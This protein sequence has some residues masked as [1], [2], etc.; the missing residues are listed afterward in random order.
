MLSVQKI[1]LLLMVMLSHPIDLLSARHKKELTVSKHM[2]PYVEKK[3]K[4]S[5]GVLD[6]LFEEKGPA[7]PH[8]IHKTFNQGTLRDTS[9]SSFVKKCSIYD[10][11]S[12]RAHFQ[13]IWLDE[14]VIQRLSFLKQQSFGWTDAERVEFEKKCLARIADKYVFYVRSEIQD[15]QYATLL[16]GAWQLLLNASGDRIMGDVK[17]NAFD[18]ET[19]LLFGSLNDM[20]SLFM[21]DH[22]AIFPKNRN[23]KK[24]ELF[25]LGVGV[26]DSISW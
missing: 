9:N 25:F 12:T 8:L 21:K 15:S 3:R 2:K 20:T 17:E 18:P 22:V 24:L 14:K 4:F 1:I 11:F 19:Q 7:N 26:H 23:D 10:Q 5:P 6:R 13:A 16:Q